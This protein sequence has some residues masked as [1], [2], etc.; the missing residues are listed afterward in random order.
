M[1]RKFGFLIV[2]GLAIGAICGV[3]FGETIENM[4]LGIALGAL[5]GVFLGWFVAL[6]AQQ[7]FGRKE[8][9]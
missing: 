3:F 9:R 6:I 1:E 4:R 5:G 8:D 7:R 2:L